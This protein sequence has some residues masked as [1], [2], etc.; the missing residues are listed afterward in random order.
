MCGIFGMVSKKPKSF[1][2]RGFFTMG[3]RNDSRGGDSCGVFIDGKVEYGVDKQKYF[4]DFFRDSLLLQ[5]T[6]ECKVA[7]GHCRKASVGKVS[8]ATAQP[9]VL[10]NESGEVDYVLIHNGTVYNYKELAQKY[11]PDVNIEGLTDSQVMARIFYHKGYDCLDE[12]NGG[13]VFVIHDYRTDKTLVFK[14]WSKKHSYSQAIEEERPLYYCW[15][16][17]RFVFSSIFESLYAF[18]YDEEIYTLPH[19]QLLVVKGSKLKVVKSYPR[20]ECCQTK[21]MTTPGMRVIRDDDDFFGMSCYGYDAYQTNSYV[22]YKIKFNGTIYQNEHGAPMH[23]KFFISTYGYVF[24]NRKTKDNW[25]HEV[26]FFNGRLLK[27]PGAFFLINEKF[28]EAGKTLTPEINILIDMMDF[29]PF[30]SD[31]IQYYWYDEDALMIPQNEWK[32]PVADWSYVFN[33]DGKVEKILKNPYYGWHTDYNMY[34]FDKG[35][36]VEAWKKVCDS[37]TQEEQ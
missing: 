7:F 23:G 14:G 10:Y 18:Y 16:N 33:A 31:G 8:E 20:L 6:D 24:P 19:N 26:A 3:V 1:N 11:I 29:N 5:T 36:I 32:Y 13:A 21:V 30:S 2:K 12:Y 37:E 22:S 17:G 28:L 4:I 15:H 27:H 9:V 34:T 35:K 25:V